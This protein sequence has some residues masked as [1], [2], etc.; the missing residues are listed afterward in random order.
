MTV[1]AQRSEPVPESS[2]RLLDAKQVAAL[3]DLPEAEVTA[4]ARLLQGVKIRGRWRFRAESI[5]EAVRIRS[6]SREDSRAQFE[7]LLDDL[8]KDLRDAGCGPE[9][10]PRLIAQVR[11]ERRASKQNDSSR[12]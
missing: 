4:R 2:A 1:R 11:R 5:R 7:G 8:G 10:V 3:L 9:D 12:A 6:M